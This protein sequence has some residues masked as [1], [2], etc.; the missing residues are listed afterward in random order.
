MNGVVWM[1]WFGVLIILRLVFVIVFVV[2]VFDVC[3]IKLFCDLLFYILCG[4]CFVEYYLEFG[5]FS[6]EVEE[7]FL[8]V[9]LRV[10]E[11]WVVEWGWMWSISMMVCCSV[12]WWCWLWCICVIII[13]IR[14]FFLFYVFLFCKNICNEVDCVF[15]FG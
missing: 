8:D 6:C 9:C 4:M 3:V 13:L 11:V 12:M 2:W 15:G 1:G 14:F 10:D 5:I 7:Y